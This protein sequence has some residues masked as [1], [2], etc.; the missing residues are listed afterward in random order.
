MTRLTW[1]EETWQ[2]MQKRERPGSFGARL[3]CRSSTKGQRRLREEQ[4]L[5]DACRILLLMCAITRAHH[6]LRNVPPEDVW[7]YAEGRTRATQSKRPKAS[8]SRPQLGTLQQRPRR[9]AGWA[10]SLP[11]ALRRPPTGAPGRA[12]WVVG[13]DGSRA[14]RRHVVCKRWSAAAPAHQP[15][16]RPTPPHSG[17]H[18]SAPLG[19]TPMLVNIVKLVR[20]VYIC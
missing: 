4:A 17:K 13:T 15:S 19:R 3:A 14:W 10:S 18:S 20:Y 1:L 12:R 6:A 7:P 5:L 2:A 8:F 16:A 11:G 9:W